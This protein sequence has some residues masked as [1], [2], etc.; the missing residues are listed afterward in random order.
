MKFFTNRSNCENIMIRDW[1]KYVI[2][3]SIQYYW[4]L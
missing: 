3:N 4:E 1:K 2:G